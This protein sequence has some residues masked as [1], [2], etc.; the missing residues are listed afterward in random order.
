MPGACLVPVV[1]LSMAIAPDAAS[2][3][4][5]LGSGTEAECIEAADRL[6]AIG[7]EALPAIESAMVKADAPARARMLAVWETIQKKA[8]P[9]PTMIRLDEVHGPMPEV[10]RAIGEQ[11]GFR[12]AWT[13]HHNVPEVAAGPPGLV[14]FWEAIEKL[15]A[16][17]CFFHQ[18]LPAVRYFP[19]VELGASVPQ[20]PTTTDGPFRILLH[21]LHESRD[22]LLIPGPWIGSNPL[23]A[24][25]QIGR[26]ATMVEQ[27]F[28]LDIEIQV[29]PRMWF[30]QVAPPR[31]IEAIDDRGRSLLPH[32][33]GDAFP[34]MSFLISEGST[35]GHLQ[36][37]LAT[38]EPS[39]RS[40][41]RLKGTVPVVLQVRR[42]LPEFDVPLVGPVG[43]TF[44]FEEVTFTLKELR[45]DPQALSVSFEIQANLEKLE[46]PPKYPPRLVTSRL[47]SLAD[48]QVEIVHPDGRLLDTMAGSGFININGQGRRNYR[49]NKPGGKP[50]LARF[51]YYRMVRVPAEVVFEFRDIPLP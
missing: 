44:P 2:L 50:V 6:A 7:R 42:P 32:E 8:M 28:Y 51:R 16:G 19:V 45:D 15:G 20:Y 48:H 38:P 21:G 34:Q 23:N 49:L 10:V 36:L 17:P 26:S 13:T 14:P 37:D 47:G 9:R 43:R 12:L 31:A 11:T 25:M 39:A 24:R 1:I 3:V 46:L 40:I 41:A 33:D 29:E 4:S 5:K 22:R 35:Q 27:R 30:G 18:E